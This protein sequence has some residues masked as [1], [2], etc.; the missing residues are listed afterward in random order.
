MQESMSTPAQAV[1]VVAKTATAP[2]LTEKM[3]KQNVTTPP[4]TSQSEN[5]KTKVFVNQNQRLEGPSKKIVIDVKSESQVDILANNPTITIS[6]PNEKSKNEQK[7][8]NVDEKKIKREI[9]L[10]MEATPKKCTGYVGFANLP[11]QVYKK[12]VKKG[13]DF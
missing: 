5:L 10:V 4:S 11:N 2:V 7:N 12:A 3:N 9:S 8:K 13:F 6:A 1:P